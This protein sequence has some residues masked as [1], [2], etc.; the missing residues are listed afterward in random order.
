MDDLIKATQKLLLHCEHFGRYCVLL[1]TRLFLIWIELNEKIGLRAPR[2][3]P[4][5]Q[6]QTDNTQGPLSLMDKCLTGLLKAAG[7]GFALCLG[8]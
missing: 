2:Q 6:V 5:S 8:P 7:R 3:Q 1:S 4:L